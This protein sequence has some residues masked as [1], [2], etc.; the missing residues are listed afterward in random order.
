MIERERESTYP[1]FEEDREIDLKNCEKNSKFWKYVSIDF[2]RWVNY[3]WEERALLQPPPVFQFYHHRATF[4]CKSFSAG[5]NFHAHL[6]REEPSEFFLLGEADFLPPELRPS[7]WARGATPRHLSDSSERWD[8]L[9]NMSLIKKK[10]WC[11]ASP[12]LAA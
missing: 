11:I 3:S 6:I 12:P 9:K 10:V 1:S 7:S 5:A 4:E 8:F 2:S